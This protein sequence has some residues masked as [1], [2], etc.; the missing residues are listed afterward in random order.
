MKI[1]KIKNFF[2]VKFNPFF[3][4]ENWLEPIHLEIV[5]INE[6]YAFSIS[7]FFSHFLRKIDMLNFNLI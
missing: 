3:L 7:V 1:K 5:F 6:H 4:L 2:F